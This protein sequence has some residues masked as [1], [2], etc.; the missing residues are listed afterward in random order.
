MRAGLRYAWS[1]AELRVPLIMMAIIGTLA[2]NFQTVLPLFATRDLHGSDLT[3]SLLM[4][5][6]SVGLPGRGA[7]LGGPQARVDPHRE[8]GRPRLRG[9]DAGPRRLSR[10]E[11]DRV[12]WSGI[13]MGFTS[14][15]F[16][17]TSTAIVQ[18]RAR[19][20]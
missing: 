16:M 12:R 3:F 18:I 11:P 8:P 19:T 20:R 6:V 1:V 15:A 9:G 13:V 7:P 17:T 14:I 10:G 2:F 5:V 4:S